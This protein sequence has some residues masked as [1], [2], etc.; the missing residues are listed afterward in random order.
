[1]G[2]TGVFERFFSSCVHATIIID[3]TVLVFLLERRFRFYYPAHGLAWC[4]TSYQTMVWDL[5]FHGTDMIHF[6]S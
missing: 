3:K 5:L 1:M 6:A 2:D 4:N